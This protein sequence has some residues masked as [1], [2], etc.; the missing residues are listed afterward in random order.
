MKFEYRVWIEVGNDIVEAN[1]M[2]YYFQRDAALWLDGGK[3][4]ALLSHAEG[5]PFEWVMVEQNTKWD[6]LMLYSGL[7]DKNNKKVYRGDIIKY[8]VEYCSDYNEETKIYTTW[9]EIHYDVVVFEHGQFSCSK[10]NFGYEG[11]NLISIREG[12]VVGNIFESPV[13]LKT[14]IVKFNIKEEKL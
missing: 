1:T 9:S 6:N 8:I 5:K 7:I 4:W 2:F 14:E 13:I 12:E 11:E 3:S 10:S